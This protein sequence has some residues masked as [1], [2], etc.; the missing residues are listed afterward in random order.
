MS[1]VSSPCL[2]KFQDSMGKRNPCLI[3]TTEGS[4]KIHTIALIKA[5]DTATRTLSH[6]W[7]KSRHGRC[8]GYTRC[9]TDNRETPWQLECPTG[10]WRAVTTRLLAASR[11][12]LFHERVHVPFVL[13]PSCRLAR[14][15]TP[16]STHLRFHVR[17]SVVGRIRSLARLCICASDTRTLTFTH[18]RGSYRRRTVGTISSGKSERGRGRLHACTCRRYEARKCACME[19]QRPCANEDVSTHV[20]V[21]TRTITGIPGCRWLYPGDAL[22]QFVTTLFVNK[23]PADEVQPY[24]WYIAESESNRPCRSCSPAP[25]S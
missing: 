11:T 4:M 5:N 13:P 9:Y 3:T 8:Q 7:F 15:S 21:C 14:L 23:V 17:A 19:Q 2:T 18:L 24:I 25:E 22:F 1:P 10:K 12:P 16:S 6:R 20:H